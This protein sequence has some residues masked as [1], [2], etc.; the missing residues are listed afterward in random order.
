MASTD[1]EY[2]KALKM[3]EKASREASAKGESPYLPAL[4]EILRDVRVVREENLGLVDIPLDQIVGTKTSGRKNAFARNFMPLISARSEFAMKWANLLQYQTSEGVT[5]PIIAYEYRNQFYVLEGNKR[6]SVFKYLHAYSI[7]GMV[8]RIVP[9]WTEDTETRIFYEFMG[10]YSRSRINYIWFTRE[11]RFPALS[12]ACGIEPGAEWT[13]EQRQMFSL[14]YSRFRGLFQEMGGGKLGITAADALLFYLGIYPYGEMDEKSDAGLKEE[15]THIWKE[16][17]VLN[18]QEAADVAMEPEKTAPAHLLDRIFASKNTLKV[19]FIHEKSLEWSAW[20]YSHELGR[21]HTA[22]VFGDQIETASYYVD[23]ACPDMEGVIRQAIEEGCTLIFTTTE[24]MLEPSLKLAILYPDIDI[25][26][27]SI[28]RSYMTLRTYYGRMY[29][30]KFLCGMIAGAMARSSGILYT[31]DCPIYGEIANINAFA[32][33]ALCV[34]PEAKVYLNWESAKNADPGRL[35]REHGISVVSGLDMVRPA[36]SRRYYGLYQTEGGRVR[37]LAAPIWNWGK[38]Y[39]KVTGQVLNGTFRAAGND[40]R[41]ARTDWWGM[42]TGLVELIMARDLPA[43]VRR[44]VKLVRSQIR[45]ETFLPFG[46]PC[47]DQDGQMHTLDTAA[48]IIEMDFLVK[49]VIGHIPE[50]DELTEDTLSLLAVSGIR[51]RKSEDAP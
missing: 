34:N 26:N 13:D 6:V 29:E 14:R 44:L 10:F 3:G 30:A 35:I 48:S 1:T 32:L 5:D 4:D 24:R 19:G 31:A 49:N 33:G 11:G 38:F 46:E 40:N 2:Q 37:N 28:T 23:P 7:E 47:A 9:E 42:S 43:G 17:S 18:R 51:S 50:E 27:C 15:I 8:T 25:L 45:Q 20:T 36:Q 39:E 22:D 16:L 41:N 12:K 21:M